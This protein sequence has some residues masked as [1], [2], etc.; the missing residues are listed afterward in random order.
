MSAIHDGFAAVEQLA[1]GHIDGLPDV[2]DVVLAQ[3]AASTKPVHLMTGSSMVRCGKRMGHWRDN[4]G[5]WYLGKSATH[6]G[7]T[8]SLHEVTCPD[9]LRARR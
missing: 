7:C 8:T 5:G 2:D 3:I 1:V 6:D 4:P 9:C